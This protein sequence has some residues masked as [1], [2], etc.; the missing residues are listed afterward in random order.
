METRFEV[1]FKEI[2]EAFCLGFEDLHLVNDGGYERGYAEG[3]DVGFAEGEN[4]GYANGYDKGVEDA[5]PSGEIELTENN[6]THDVAAYATAS[7]AVPSPEIFPPIIVEMFDQVQW[8]NNEKNGNF[9]VTITATVDGEEVTSPLMITEEMNGKNLIIK[10]EC[11]NFKGTEHRIPLVYRALDMSDPTRSVFFTSGVPDP[12]NAEYPYRPVFELISIHYLAGV[13]CIAVMDDVTHQ[14]DSSHNNFYNRIEF[15]KLHTEQF[16]IEPTEAI[17]GAVCYP[18]LKYRNIYT[19]GFYQTSGYSKSVS[20]TSG[21]IKVKVYVNG[22]FRAQGT[23]L[24]YIAVG[25]LAVGD[26]ITFFIEA[27]V[28]N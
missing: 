27:H 23:A 16:Y 12:P 22:E 8:K 18:S 9:A 24:G 28:A 4:V 1:Q 11:E 25:D 15:N 19:N 7:V 17:T 3:H 20:W 2:V 26:K 10:A 21:T 6:K 14:R 5:T 13:E